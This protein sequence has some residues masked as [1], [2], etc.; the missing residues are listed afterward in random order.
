[1]R[2]FCPQCGS[3]LLFEPLDKPDI[4]ETY[5]GAL[6]TPGEIAPGLHIWT[7]SAVPW[8]HIDDDL[9]RFPENRPPGYGEQR[10]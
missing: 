6:D 7:S 8:L 1:V 9:E 10:P 2:H 5:I 3:P 4:L